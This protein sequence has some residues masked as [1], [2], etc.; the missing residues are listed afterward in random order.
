MGPPAPAP[1]GRRGRQSQE[2]PGCRGRCGRRRPKEGTGATA[3]RRNQEE[4]LSSFVAVLKKTRYR[5]YFERFIHAIIFAITWFQM[6]IGLHAAAIATSVTHSQP[7]PGAGSSLSIVRTFLTN[8]RRK[9]ET[10]GCWNT[11]GQRQS[12]QFKGRRVQC[13]F[14]FKSSFGIG[15]KIRKKRQQ[16]KRFGIFP[17]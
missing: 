4:S 16:C 6:T 7:L 14:V 8:Q 12:L 3:K 2:G 1:R 5:C 15:R 10:P 13:K 17:P 11:V 9:F